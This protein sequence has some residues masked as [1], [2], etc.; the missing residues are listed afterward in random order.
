MGT[1]VLILKTLGND[2]QTVARCI[3][4]RIVDLVGVP[5]EDDLRI[6][7]ATRDHRLDLVSFLLAN[8]LLMSNR[9]NSHR[10]AGAPLET[11]RHTMSAIPSKRPL[12]GDI[13]CI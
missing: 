8:D 4:V 1:D 12:S 11:G 6:G 10:N 3:H 2:G 13:S 9:F 5:G 7:A